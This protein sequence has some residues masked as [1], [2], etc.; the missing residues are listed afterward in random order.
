MQALPFSN[1][2]SDEDELINLKSL[3][4]LY[5]SAKASILCKGTN[6]PENRLHLWTVKSQSEMF[7]RHIR[8]H[9]SARHLAKA[10]LGSPIQAHLLGKYVC[11]LWLHA[12]CH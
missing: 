12:S 8:L 1:H 3:L 7:S 2:G 5:A 10:E 9:Q 4:V 11:W 6:Y